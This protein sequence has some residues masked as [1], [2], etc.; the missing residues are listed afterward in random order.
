MSPDI[1]M[2]VT[3]IFKKNN[4]TY[5]FVSFTEGKKMAEFRLPEVKLTYNVGFDQS[6][7]EALALYVRQTNEQIYDMAK[8]VNVMK[9]FM[10][11]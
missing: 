2:S 6:E 4:S 11:N 1:N 9:A 8:K 10:E 5:Y 7:T 3:Q